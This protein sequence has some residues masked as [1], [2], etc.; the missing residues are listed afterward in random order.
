MLLNFVKDFSFVSTIIIYYHTFISKDHDNLFTMFFTLK[1]F[2]ILVVE[3]LSF[4]SVIKNF[5]F[6]GL[7]FSCILSAYC[8]KLRQ[9]YFFKAFFL[10][11][12]PIFCLYTRWFDSPNPFL[13]G[14]DLFMLIWSSSAHYFMGRTLLYLLTMYNICVLEIFTIRNQMSAY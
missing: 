11:Y 10:Q 5:S 14:G 9:I 1:M 2:R 8:I 4:I 13:G 6:T 3:Y 12:L 7:S